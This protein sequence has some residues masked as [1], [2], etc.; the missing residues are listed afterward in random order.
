MATK[1]AHYRTQKYE[2]KT[3]PISVWLLDKIVTETSGYDL[4]ST[5][6]KPFVLI[7]P[8]I[9]QAVD[10]LEV[11]LTKRNILK[12]K[13]YSA[14]AASRKW[15]QETLKKKIEE[16]FAQ[17]ELWFVTPEL[18]EELVDTML[19]LKTVEFKVADEEII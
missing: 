16:I 3:V 2:A 6:I 13:L 11:P 18:K 17:M 10:K 4:W 14:W 8:S 12:T 19:K 15:T 7:Q 9:E 1:P 5:Q